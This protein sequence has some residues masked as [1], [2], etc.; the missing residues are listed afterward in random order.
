MRKART[1]RRTRNTSSTWSSTTSKTNKKKDEYTQGHDEERNDGDDRGQV[2]RH[3]ADAS[4]TDV[5][6]DNDG[7]DGAIVTTC[8]RR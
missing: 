5:A 3:D 2:K 8:D 1:R 6:D 7:H 4:E